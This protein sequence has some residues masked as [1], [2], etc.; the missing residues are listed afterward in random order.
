MTEIITFSPAYR[1]QV[2]PFVL[3]VQHEFGVPITLADQPDLNAIEQY[4]ITPGG[5]FWLAL[6]GDKVVG[7]A[8][9]LRVDAS[10]AIMRKLFVAPAHRGAA[11]VGKKLL[12]TMLEWAH[13]NHVKNIYLGT[14]NVFRAACRFYEKHGF[15]RLSEAQLPHAIAAQKMKVDDTFYCIE[16]RA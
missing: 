11:A 14:V 7:T 9:L 2:G 16:V 1:D 6:D 5:N 10:S 8:A 12:D 4:Y 15:T 13:G 3:S